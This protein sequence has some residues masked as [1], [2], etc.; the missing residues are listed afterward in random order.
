MLIDSVGRESI[1][2]S[3]H[4]FHRG[5]ALASIPAHAANIKFS[6]PIFVLK[7]DRKSKVSLNTTLQCIRRAV[8]RKRFQLRRHSG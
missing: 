4:I 5:H 8:N 3:P 2:F 7:D 1:Q 6:V